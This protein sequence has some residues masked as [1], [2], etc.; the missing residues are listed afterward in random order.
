MKLHDIFKAS[1]DIDES[2]VVLMPGEPAMFTN[3]SGINYDVSLPHVLELETIRD[4]AFHLITEEEEFLLF[5]TGSSSHNGVYRS[6]GFPPFR[7]S[8]VQRDDY[9]LVQ[10]Y[11][12]ELDN[13]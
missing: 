13:A 11:S 5:S 8:I 1:L 7:Y 9:V 12:E 2:S 3:S 10:F 6:S 4:I